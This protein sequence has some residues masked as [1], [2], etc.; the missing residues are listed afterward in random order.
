MSIL[1]CNKF[2]QLP[3]YIS[4]LIS[5]AAHFQHFKYSEQAIKASVADPRIDPDPNPEKKT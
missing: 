1:N 2:Y 4:F 3:W 5:E